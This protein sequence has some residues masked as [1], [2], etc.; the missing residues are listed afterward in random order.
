MQN[1]VVGVI[2]QYLIFLYAGKYLA[3]NPDI[4]DLSD[5]A[6]DKAFYGCVMH[7]K[8]KGYYTQVRA[9]ILILWKLKE[10]QVVQMRMI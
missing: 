5:Q 8:I 6:F 7:T 1:E 10:N 3:D 2:S 9:A 4:D